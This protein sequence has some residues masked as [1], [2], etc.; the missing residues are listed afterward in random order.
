MDV[1]ALETTRS[2]SSKYESRNY[3]VTF[4]IYL[5]D[6]YEENY[7]FS[8]PVSGLFEFNYFVP[9]LP[10]KRPGQVIEG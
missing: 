5:K 3:C 6:L 9:G 8:K 4:G 7:T 10:V 1:I 2:Q